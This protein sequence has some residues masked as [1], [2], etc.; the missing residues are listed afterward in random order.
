MS[1]C[2]TFLYTSRG[3]EY[4]LERLKAVFVG[5]A[6][7]GLKPKLSKRPCSLS[8]VTLLGNIAMGSGVAI[9][10]KRIA[11]I[12]DAPLPKTT[13]ELCSIHAQARYY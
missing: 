7:A 1:I 10:P 12:K 4:R 9:D 6:K 13:T 3:S 5:T 2:L 11:A 8:G